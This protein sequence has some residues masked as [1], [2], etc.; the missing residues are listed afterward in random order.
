MTAKRNL[1][2][3]EEVEVGG[4]QVRGVAAGRGG[5]PFQSESCCRSESR[6][7]RVPRAV[8]QADEVVAIR[9]PRASRPR[10]QLAMSAVLP[11]PEP[12]VTSM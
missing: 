3:S 1:A 6:A 9:V 11:L 4:L 2:E 5:S 7:R 8:L 12:P 10:I